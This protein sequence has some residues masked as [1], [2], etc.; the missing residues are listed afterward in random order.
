M[1]F[2]VSPLL[3]IIHFCIENSIFTNELKFADVSALHKKTRQLKMTITGQLA[4]YLRYQKC[5]RESVKN[6]GLNSS[7]INCLRY[8]AVSENF[9]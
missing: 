6:N 5:S 2:H 4:F 9:I 3:K 8:F 7:Q 1:L